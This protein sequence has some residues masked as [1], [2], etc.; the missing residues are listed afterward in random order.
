MKNHLV[1]K[2]PIFKSGEDEYN[3]NNLWYIHKD[4][5]YHKRFKK[6]HFNF[7]LDSKSIDILSSI[8]LTNMKKRCSIAIV[9]GNS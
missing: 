2:N 9:I 7:F 6:F 8:L 4:E 3:F 1:T 5:Y